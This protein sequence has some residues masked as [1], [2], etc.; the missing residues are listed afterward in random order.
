LKIRGKLNAMWGRSFSFS[1]ESS[2]I[3]S[4]SQT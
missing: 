1:S 2:W 4:Y 3:R